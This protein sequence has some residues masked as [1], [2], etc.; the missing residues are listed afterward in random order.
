MKMSDYRSME[1]MIKT[2]IKSPCS[3][4]II[5]NGDGTYKMVKKLFDS[6]E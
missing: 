6:V 4:V 1:L 5:E 2:G 3:V